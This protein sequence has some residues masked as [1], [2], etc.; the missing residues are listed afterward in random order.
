M[1]ENEHTYLHFYK[2]D[3]LETIAFSLHKYYKREFGK[4][5]QSDSSLRV[6]HGCSLG[7]MFDKEIE[8][9][10]FKDWDQGQ[11]RLN[12]LVQYWANKGFKTRKEL[13]IIDENDDMKHDELV[14]YIRKQLF[15]LYNQPK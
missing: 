2:A 7:P 5:V 3:T 8:Y 4:R 14:A 15:E 13:G 11:A 12:E 1:L 9:S 10:K 6:V